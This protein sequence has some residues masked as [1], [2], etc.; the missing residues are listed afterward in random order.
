MRDDFWMSIT[1]PFLWRNFAKAKRF[2]Y[3]PFILLL[4]TRWT[5]IFSFSYL[6][7]VANVTSDC[8][9]LYQT[10]ASYETACILDRRFFTFP[11]QPLQWQWRDSKNNHLVVWTRT[12]LLFLFHGS[13]KRKIKLSPLCFASVKFGFWSWWWLGTFVLLHLPQISGWKRTDKLCR[14]RPI[15][16]GIERTAPFS[17]LM[18]CWVAFCFC[19][20]ASFHWKE[21]ALNGCFRGRL[22]IVSPQGLELCNNGEKVSPAEGEGTVMRSISERRLFRVSRSCT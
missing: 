22:G 9:F 18:L 7:E 14:R 15:V 2:L 5:W 10:W 6:N 11:S 20:K 3:W 1:S 21:T 17:K 19:L 13:V 4:E 12:N 8:A 16:G